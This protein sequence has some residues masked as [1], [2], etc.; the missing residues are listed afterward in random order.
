MAARGFGSHAA[1]L[2]AHVDWHMMS[3]Q[4]VQGLTWWKQRMWQVLFHKFPSLE[5]DVE[6]L[7]LYTLY[8]HIYVYIYVDQKPMYWSI[9]MTWTKCIYGKPES[10]R[11]ECPHAGPMSSHKKMAADCLCE[12]WSH[13]V[14]KIMHAI[15]TFEKT[16][17]K[18]HTSWELEIQ[19]WCIFR[20]HGSFTKH[21]EQRQQTSFHHSKS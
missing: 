2:P 5:K 7:Y 8:T 13:S 16:R 3:S 21:P 10:C 12:V 17:Y 6:K 18:H 11:V 14:V 19:D 9:I 1:P 4:P 20:K 15:Q